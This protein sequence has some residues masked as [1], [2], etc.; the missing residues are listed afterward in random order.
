M[1]TL[2]GTIVSIKQSDNLQL[3][4]I[5]VEGH[6]FSSLVIAS[7]ENRLEVSMDVHLLFKET[8]VTLA[9]TSSVVSER[10]AF[11]SKITHIE[12]GKLL[13][14]ITLDFLGNNINAIITKGALHG[15]KCKIGDEFL[16]VVKANEVTLQNK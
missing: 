13:A 6:L 16:W 1:N 4:F 12:N 11:C 2:K 14:N 15:L 9:T 5:D 10:N 8:E 3:I 7:D